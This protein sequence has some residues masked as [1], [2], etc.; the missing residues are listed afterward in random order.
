MNEYL[1]A[2]VE[3]RLKELKRRED[4]LYEQLKQ[5]NER[6]DILKYRIVDTENEIKGLELFLQNE[7][8]DK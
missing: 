2:L 5:I 7:K 3:S 8:E 1:K 4:G 6:L